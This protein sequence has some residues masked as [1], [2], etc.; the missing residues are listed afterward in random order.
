MSP[1]D[2]ALTSI[3][4][5][6]GARI[7][8]KGI[9]RAN[10]FIKRT[11]EDQAQVATQFVERRGPNRAKNVIRPEF[12]ISTQPAVFMPEDQIRVINKQNGAM[13]TVDRKTGTE[14]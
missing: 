14:G 6:V 10:H 3:L 7:V 8:V 5:V 2:I 11:N 9:Q 12:G 1:S 4:A 13:S